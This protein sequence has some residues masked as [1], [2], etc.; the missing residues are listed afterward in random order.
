ML[1]EVDRAISRAGLRQVMSLFQDTPEG[2]DIVEAELPPQGLPKLSAEST[3]EKVDGSI[4][5]IAASLFHPA[6]SASMGKVVDT[7][8]KVKGMN[9]LRVV[10]ASVLPISLCA[11]SG[12]CLCYC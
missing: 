12:S 8:L 2:R 4:R 1:R 3:N 9:G 5:R 7:E 10:D 11:H 6:G